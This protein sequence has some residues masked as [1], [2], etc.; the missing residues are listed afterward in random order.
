MVH[1]FAGKLDRPVESLTLYE[2]QAMGW[3][4]AAGVELLDVGFE[5]KPVILKFLRERI[6]V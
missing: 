1:V 3:F 2:G 6:G 5:K 4:D